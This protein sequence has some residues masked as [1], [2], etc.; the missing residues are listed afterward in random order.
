MSDDA[1]SHDP[2]A[3]GAR[4]ASR[5]SQDSPAARGRGLRARHDA[6]A[7]GPS[8]HDD[9]AWAA[10]S[11]RL[12]ADGATACGRDAVAPVDRGESAGR[13]AESGTAWISHVVRA[14]RTSPFQRHGRG[15]AEVS[16]GPGVLDEIEDLTMG[17]NARKVREAFGTPE[18]LR[19]LPGSNVNRRTV[20]TATG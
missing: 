20:V 10:G 19:S 13:S 17:R 1:T 8:R 7:W 9:D 6:H 12:S 14:E 2:P 11:V 15:P 5:V 18:G 16:A 4:R 3:T